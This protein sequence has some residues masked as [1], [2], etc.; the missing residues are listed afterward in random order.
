M[1]YY[2]EYNAYGH[3]VTEFNY[4]YERNLFLDFYKEHKKIGWN[5]DLKMVSYSTELGIDMV[6]LLVLEKLVDPNDL[7]F[8]YKD[9][10]LTIDSDAIFN[11][12]ESSTVCEF[13][14]CAMNVA[15]RIMEARSRNRKEER[16]QLS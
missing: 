8:I 3:A 6:R 14:S 10:I 13:C 5:K 15:K 1:I 16:D 2:I 12:E 11:A 7:R 4:D 9:K